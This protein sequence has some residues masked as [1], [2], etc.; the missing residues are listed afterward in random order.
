[1]L[2]QVI[3]GNAINYTIKGVKPWPKLYVRIQN[4]EPI[5]SLKNI[6]A[7]YMSMLS[8]FY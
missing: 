6:K 1:L 7:N 2:H 4:Y 8:S 5:T 3:Y